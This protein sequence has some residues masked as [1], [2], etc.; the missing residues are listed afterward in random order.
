LGGLVDD[1]DQKNS[2]VRSTAYP[3]IATDLNFSDFR[4]EEVL[5]RFQVACQKIAVV[6]FTVRCDD[7]VGLSSLESRCSSHHVDHLIGFEKLFLVLFSP[8]KNIMVYNDALFIQRA[9]SISGS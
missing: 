8:S 1:L 4:V 7:G 9:P 6:G 5:V 3:S 2:F